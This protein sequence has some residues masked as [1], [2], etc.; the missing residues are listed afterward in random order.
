MDS[1]VP[2]VHFLFQHMT[3]G[4]NANITALNSGCQ[5]NKNAYI[6]GE[7]TIQLWNATLGQVEVSL[8][9]FCLLIC[10]LFMINLVHVQ[11]HWIQLQIP[12][13]TE[14]CY[15]IKKASSPPFR[16]IYHRP[17]NFNSFFVRTK[18]SILMADTGVAEIY[19]RQSLMCTL[20]S[21]FYG[22]LNSDL[23]LRCPNFT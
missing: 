20:S 13:R 10:F 8:T 5:W 2:V 9:Y 3:A 4:N 15:C 22:I 18:N 19:Y 17:F 11:N 1:S 7:A 14:I 21:V 23:K 12:H 6:L 16:C